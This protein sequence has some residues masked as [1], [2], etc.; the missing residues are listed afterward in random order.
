MRLFRRSQREFEEEIRT[1]LEIETDQLIA[2]GHS[3][4]DARQLA[5]RRFGNVGRAQERYYNSSPIAW[6]HD[7]V[8][9][10]RYAFRMMHKRPGFSVSVMLIAA[11]GLVACVTTFS[12]VSGILLK[13]FSFGRQDRVFMVDMNGPGIQTAALP[14]S[15]YDSL[16]NAPEVAAIGAT[17]PNSITL[18]NGEELVRAGARMA[19]A[20][21]F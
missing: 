19:T 5:R 8:T 10:A 2:E 20:S 14:I 17:E 13:P 21:L 12:L 1:H 4:R 3:P 18:R 7:A 11:L 16:A 9:D 15:V 6:L